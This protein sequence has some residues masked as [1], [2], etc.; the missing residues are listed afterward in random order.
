M[1]AATEVRRILD[2]GQAD[3]AA[4]TRAP[5]NLA[6]A[7]VTAARTARIA[8]EQERGK[9]RLAEMM[10]YRAGRRRNKVIT[11]FENLEEL[12]NLGASIVDLP[13]S[14]LSRHREWVLELACRIEDDLTQDD[15][16]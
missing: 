16:A 3:A 8:V 13:G 6:D 4:I 2:A 10:E 1:N 14:M 15:A 11:P 7:D 5:R 12:Q 9:T